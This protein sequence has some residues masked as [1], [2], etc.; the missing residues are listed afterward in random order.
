MNRN[1]INYQLRQLGANLL[2]GANSPKYYISLPSFNNWLL[3]D[4]KP[5]ASI[6][7]FKTLQQLHWWLVNKS[8]DC[9]IR[10]EC[11]ALFEFKKAENFRP[12]G[13]FTGE[14][15]KVLDKNSSLYGVEV[16]LAKIFNSDSYHV[17][18]NQE[19][20]YVNKIVNALDVNVLLIEY[21]QAHI[22]AMYFNGDLIPS[23]SMIS[24]IKYIQKEYNTTPV[25]KRVIGEYQVQ[26]IDFL[27]TIKI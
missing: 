27:S 19:D 2:V 7:R 5:D 20:F 6:I 3:T 22:K 26:V 9:V 12:T 14:K 10:N 11:K 24:A 21:D 4:G 25:G 1:Q 15:V 17:W 23:N 13:H 18:H 8:G 16:T